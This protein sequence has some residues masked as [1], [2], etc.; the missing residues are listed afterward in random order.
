MTV[1][2]QRVNWVQTVVGAVLGAVMVGLLALSGNGLSAWATANN[3]AT[4]NE[5]QDRALARDRQDIDQLKVDVAKLQSI[6]SDTEYIRTRL[7]DHMNGE[8]QGKP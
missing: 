8:R 2:G 3:A 7:D 1:S 5:E 4:K 6:K